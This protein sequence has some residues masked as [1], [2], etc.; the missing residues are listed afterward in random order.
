MPRILLSG[1]EPFDR[2]TVNPSW[3]VARALD[4]W[5][6]DG[7]TVQAVRLPCVFGEALERLD[8]A[9][10]VGERPVLVIGLGLAGGR[11]EVTPE[12]AALNVDDARIPDNAGRQPVDRPV[13]AQG[14]AAYFS[15]LPVKAIVQALRRE[16]LP[17]SVSNSAGTFVCNHV[18]YGLMHRLATQAGLQGVRGGFVH[19]PAL[20]E[21]AARM[22]GMPSLGLE[23][24]VQALRVLLQ[25]AL[26][27]Q[28]DLR[29]QGGSL[30]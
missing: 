16:G 15:T 11:T 14:P 4:G 3:E 7:A 22:P 6:V 28:T 9:L 1:F 8:A 23:M 2:D 5:Q 24:Q 27:V 25:T 21:Q 12:R 30:R 26:T 13:V 10:A 20:P 29:E 18:F 17:A 19:V